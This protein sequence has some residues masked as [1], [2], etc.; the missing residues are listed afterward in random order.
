MEE[1]Y[2]LGGNFLKIYVFLTW[3]LCILSQIFS[4]DLRDD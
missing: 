2:T 3:K 4:E 1:E